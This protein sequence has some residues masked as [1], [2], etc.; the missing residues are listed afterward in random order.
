MKIS[1]LG[2]EFDDQD[3]R[4]ILESDRNSPEF[5]E[6]RKRLK[7]LSDIDTMEAE[8]RDDFEALFNL[9]A[10]YLVNAGRIDMPK[11][12]RLMFEQDGAELP[13]IKLPN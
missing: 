8:C 1:E 3:I 2:S 6:I 4:E 12:G 13:S 7:V 9:A 11:G 10:D 5:L